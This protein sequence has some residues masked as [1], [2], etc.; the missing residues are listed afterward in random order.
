MPTALPFVVAALPFMTAGLPFMLC[1]LH[2][3]A[4]LALAL[5]PVSATAAARQTDD[6]RCACAHA[7]AELER[8]RGA[9][10]DEEARLRELKRQVEEAQQVRGVSG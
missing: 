10:R 6:V 7:A 8:S 5:M 3:M 9:A 1:E 2:C 4:R